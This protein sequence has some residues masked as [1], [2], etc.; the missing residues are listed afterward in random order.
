MPRRHL[1]WLYPFRSLISSPLRRSNLPRERGKEGRTYIF[2]FLAYLATSSPSKRGQRGRKS[3]IPLNWRE[4]GCGTRRPINLWL[5]LSLPPSFSVGKSRSNE[6]RA[7]EKRSLDD[8]RSATGVAC[9]VRSFIKRS[10]GGG[11]WIFKRFP[12][13]LAE[14][15]SG[16]ERAS[17][18][19]K[20]LNEC[21]WYLSVWGGI[22]LNISI[23]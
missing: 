15:G 7:R 11:G 13:R 16:R 14:R 3:E 19:E 6:L 9:K 12:F 1:T 4:R 23:Y 20:Q 17:H 22:V 18:G 8:S 5:F 21:R 10:R 2:L